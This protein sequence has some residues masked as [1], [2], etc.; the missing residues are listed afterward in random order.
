M[1][2]LDNAQLEWVRSFHDSYYA[3]NLAVPLHRR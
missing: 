3:P 1:Q 2:D